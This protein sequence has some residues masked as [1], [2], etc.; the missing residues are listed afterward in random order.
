MMMS[1]GRA[2][3]R[4]EVMQCREVVKS[5]EEEEVEVRKSYTA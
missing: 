2:N 1:V 3:G 5:A 4:L